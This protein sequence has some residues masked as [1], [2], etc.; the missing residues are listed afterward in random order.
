MA[1]ISYTYL[2]LNLLY[3]S[4]K[5]QLSEMTF[6]DVNKTCDNNNNNNTLDFRSRDFET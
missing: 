5:I 1:E 6:T 2:Q 3:S 4:Y